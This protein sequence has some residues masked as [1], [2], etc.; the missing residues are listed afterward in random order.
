MREQ[1]QESKE[2]TRALGQAALFKPSTA[3]VKETYQRILRLS[4]SRRKAK[5]RFGVIATGLA[6]EGE[7]IAFNA[8]FQSPTA[9]DVVKRIQLGKGEE[10]DDADIIEIQDDFRLAYCLDGKVY[11]TGVASS[12]VPES[13]YNTPLPA[14][15]SPQKTRSK[16]R[17]L[18]FLTPE[19]LLLLQNRPHRSGADLILLEIASGHVV[20]QK[21]LHRSIGS[22]T[23]LS[24]SLLPS[25][26][27]HDNSQ[28]AIAIAGQDNSISIFTLDHP[29][30]APF[31]ACKLR[32]YTILR[33]VHEFQT[34]SLTF[35]IFHIPSDLT[36]APPQYLK[37]ASTSVANTVVVH[38]LPLSPYP[39]ASAKQRP[40]RYVLTSP[41][42]SESAQ[43]SLSVLISVI[44]VA[45]GA[46]FLQA[47]TEIRGSAP[48]YLGAKGWLGD[49]MHGWLARPY[50]FDDALDKLNVPGLETRPMKGVQSQVGE[51]KDGVKSTVKQ[52]EIVEVPG[53]GTNPVEEVKTQ[54]AEGAEK[55]HE[56]KQKA[57]ES[58]ER[59]AEGAKTATANAQEKVEQASERV[60]EGAKAASE[61][62]QQSA[63]EVAEGAKDNAK[64]AQ[65]KLGLRDLLLRGSPMA[66]HSASSNIVIKH[67]EGSRSLSA[68]I[69]DAETIVQDGHKK[70]ED[71][72]HHE[73]EKWKR[74][75]ID[76]GEWTVEEG[77]AVLTGVFFQNIGVAVGEAV[78]AA[79]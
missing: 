18:R 11:T 7:V 78:R 14:A 47:F 4:R 52:P 65:E 44:V 43:M 51:I 35:S 68:D 61:S 54:A 58:G 37:L 62:A 16:L 5:T 60:A 25:A 8:A 15:S 70:W 66:G 49:R 31:S 71:L 72:E 64:S 28:S 23:A 9:N 39:H 30:E 76:A 40:T 29:M 21:K 6:P 55:V 13:V 19:L 36:T 42:R 69:H 46:F 22:A 32:Q 20:L 26:N 3:P 56:Q 1:A 59:V 53:V 12:K 2:V 74:K 57:K 63:E 41:G 10:A 67:D 50:M 48:E 73:R 45:L 34:T 17:S 33:N 24:V 79:M 27:S 75:L 38:T 77:E